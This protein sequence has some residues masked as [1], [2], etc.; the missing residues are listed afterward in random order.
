MSEKPRASLCTI[1]ANGPTDRHSLSGIPTNAV[2]FS[3]F[4]A[5]TDTIT[6]ALSAT[7]RFANAAL[8]NNGTDTFFASVGGDL[9]SAPSVGCPVP[10]NCA[11]W[12]FDWYVSVTNNSGALYEVDLLYDLDPGVGTNKAALGKVTT[13]PSNT[14]GTTL[15]QDSWNNGMAFLNTGVTAGVTLPTFTPFS[16]NAAGEYSYALILSRATSS[17]GALTEIGSVG[18]NVNSTVPE[19]TSMLLLGTGLLGLVVRRRNRRLKS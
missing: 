3:T 2:A 18:I 10:A 6:L 11:T 12:N 13:G 17:T 14:L 15:R 9:L 19:P 5:G 4:T 8:S 7:Q 1:L 16:P